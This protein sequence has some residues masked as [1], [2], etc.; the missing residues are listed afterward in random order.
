MTAPPLPVVRRMDFPFDP[1]VVPRWW[2][3]GDRLLTLHSNGLHL[4][5]PLGERFFVRSVGHYLPRL[6]DPQLKAQVRAFVGQEA[7][8]GKEHEASFEMLEAQGYELRS[9]LA[10]YDR[11]AWKTLE[12]LA[13]PRLRLAVTV[14]LEHFTAALGEGALTD[15]LLDHAHPVMA[16]LL[17]WH[18]CEEIEHK[19]VAFD[20]YT[21]VGGGYLVRMLGLLVAILGLLFFW[22]S[23]ARHLMRQDGGVDRAGMRALRRR[24]KAQGFDRSTIFVRCI[25][26][27]LRPGFHPDQR[28]NR[29]AA[30]A[31]LEARGRLAG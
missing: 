8:H 12:P 20:V 13:P 1:A 3:M 21:A 6:T 23:A 17:R 16:D 29:G 2:F 28:D 15:G 24:L 26:D 27:Y 19:A 4:V 9:W 11:V 14:A 30:A 10:W 22:G 25:L 7:A 18:A 5:F 31:W